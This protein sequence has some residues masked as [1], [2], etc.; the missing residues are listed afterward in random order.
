MRYV[1][2][3]TKEKWRL[4][5]WLKQKFK[6][7]ICNNCTSTSNI[8]VK[9]ECQSNS[10][11]DSSTSHNFMILFCNRNFVFLLEWYW[12]LETW[13]TH[14]TKIELDDTT[15]HTSNKNEI[16]TEWWMKRLCQGQN[17]CR[18]CI[19]RTFGWLH[20]MSTNDFMEWTPQCHSEPNS[21]NISSFLK[22]NREMM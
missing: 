21:D 10:H 12:K 18:F 6:N 3:L 8:C 17:F 4:I 7:D 13:K 5:W 16:N 2:F 22:L 14:K 19:L 9:I 15:K 11:L 1:H 20:I